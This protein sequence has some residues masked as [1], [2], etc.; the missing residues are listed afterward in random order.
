MVVSAAPT[1]TNLY[2]L[3]WNSVIGTPVLMSDRLTLPDGNVWTGAFRKTDLELAHLS[4]SGGYYRMYE[5][6]PVHD[7]KTQVLEGPYYSII[8]DGRVQRTW[9]V[10]NMTEAELADRQA[11]DVA[12]LA[13]AKRRKHQEVAAARWAAAEAGVYIDGIRLHTDPD[14]VN[15]ING[16]AF[17]ALATVLDTNAITDPDVRAMIA[18]LPSPTHWKAADQWVQLTPKQTLQ[19]GLAVRMHYQ[20]CFDRSKELD[21]QIDACTTLDAVEAIQW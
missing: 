5:K 1:A 3:V 13:D 10:R 2:C 9:D 8:G 11:K 6:R 7:E 16:A 19:A 20:S 4:S 14:S 15:M 17:S 21:A 18:A 12:A